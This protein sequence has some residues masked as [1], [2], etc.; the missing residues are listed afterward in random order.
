MA[1]VIELMID[2]E[3]NIDAIYSDSLN[4]FS[5]EAEAPLNAVC[6]MTNIE[7][8]CHTSSKQEGWVVRSAEYQNYALRENPETGG[9]VLAKDESAQEHLSLLYFQS[10]EAAKQMEVKH[11]WEFMELLKQGT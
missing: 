10:R 4:A 8:E 2:E 3:A 5:K 11:F 6:R 7:W 9:T 1:D